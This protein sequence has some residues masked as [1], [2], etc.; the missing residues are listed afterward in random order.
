MQ[1]R[2]EISCVALA[3]ANHNFFDFNDF[4]QTS[5]ASLVPILQKF[6]LDGGEEEAAET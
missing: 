4:K 2:P 1:A 5:V 3:P 6:S